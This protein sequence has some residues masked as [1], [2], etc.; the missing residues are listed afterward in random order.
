VR[1]GLLR[2]G[3]CEELPTWDSVCDGRSF[4]GLVCVRDFLWEGRPVRGNACVRN[5]L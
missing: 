4:G 2:D 3:V 1:D 5:S